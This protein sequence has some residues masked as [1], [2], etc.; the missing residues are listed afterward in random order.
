M[1]HKGRLGDFF[2][3]P[4]VSEGYKNAGVRYK[5]W[6]QSQL[7]NHRAVYNPSPR[8]KFQKN[9][10]VSNST[11]AELLPH[12]KHEARCFPKAVS[13]REIRRNNQFGQTKVC[14]HSV[15]IFNI[16]KVF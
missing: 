13:L 2:T 11:F 3:K 4:D 6:V 15:F 5:I 1:D 16:F 14:Y 12:I 9:V 10:P 8:F 7:L